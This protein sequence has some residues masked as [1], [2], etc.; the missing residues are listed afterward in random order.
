M[1]ENVANRPDLF[2]DNTAREHIIRL[3]QRFLESRVF[4]GA[5]SGVSGKFEDSSTSFYRFNMENDYIGAP[6]RLPFG[7]VSNSQGFGHNQQRANSE[8]DLTRVEPRAATS[9]TS[10]ISTSTFSPNRNGITKHFSFMRKQRNRKLGN[11]GIVEN[12]NVEDEG[13]DLFDIERRT[14]EEC[15]RVRLLQ[16]LDLP[17]VEEFVSSNT[18]Q[19]NSEHR[20]IHPVHDLQDFHHQFQS[21]TDPWIKRAIDVLKHVP[22]ARLTLEKIRQ[23]SITR[24]V[25]QQ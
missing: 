10:T 1:M 24:Q 23:Y 16:L 21:S 22:N 7:D 14:E 5:S 8:P 3:C 12:M 20:T 9:S 17:F 15:V 2:A 19:T 18:G 6:N 25:R 11:A 4:F 13:G